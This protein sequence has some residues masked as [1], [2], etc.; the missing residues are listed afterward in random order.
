[1]AKTS[2][3]AIE[4]VGRSGRVSDVAGKA[5]MLSAGRFNQLVDRVIRIL[6]GWLD[7][8]IAEIDRLLGVI[9]NMSDVT[10]RVV[11]VLK[12]LHPATRPVGGRHGRAV[13]R[14]VNDVTSSG[15]MGQPEV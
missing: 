14:K 8:T 4:G 3:K 9:A 2:M 1:M 13:V 7:T 12:V 6:G 15:Q 11:S 5:K 10:S